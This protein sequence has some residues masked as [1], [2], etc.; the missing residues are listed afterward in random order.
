VR[1]KCGISLELGRKKCEEGKA[2]TI[3]KLARPGMNSRKVVFWTVPM[4]KRAQVKVA[5]TK[6]RAR[7]LQRKR[8]E[9]VVFSRKVKGG[10]GTGRKFLK[11]EV[12]TGKT[13]S[14]GKR[15]GKIEGPSTPQKTGKNPSL[16]KESKLQKREGRGTWDVRGGGTKDTPLGGLNV[17]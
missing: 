10:E 4:G 6:A 2:H 16:W 12:W 9:V 7:G 5:E 8:R 13:F 1:R 11:K 3:F 17:N 14:K 15:E